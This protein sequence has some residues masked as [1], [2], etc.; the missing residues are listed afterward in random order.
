VPAKVAGNGHVPRAE[1]VGLRL[2]VLVRAAEPVDED[3]R[4]RTRAGACV[5]EL[6]AV[7]RGVG[8]AGLPKKA[9]LK[10]R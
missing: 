2:P 10:L 1:G 6:R 8:H 7:H 4:R 9:N 3:E 5:V